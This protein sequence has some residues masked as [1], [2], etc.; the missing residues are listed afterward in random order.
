[1]QNKIIWFHIWRHVPLSFSV[2]K[3]HLLFSLYFHRYTHGSVWVLPEINLGIEGA[4]KAWPILSSGNTTSRRWWSDSTD[5]NQGFCSG[6]KGT[7]ICSRV[8]LEK[9][10]VHL[11]P[12]GTE[13]GRFIL[14]FPPRWSIQAA[15]LS[16]AQLI[17]NNHWS[18]RTHRAPLP[19]SLSLSSEECL[20]L[21]VTKSQRERRTKLV[22]RGELKMMEEIRVGWNPSTI[23]CLYAADFCLEGEKRQ[24]S[25]WACATWLKESEHL[26]GEEK[27]PLPK[28]EPVSMGPGHCYNHP[29]R[30]P[31][32]PPST[33]A[34][35][36]GRLWLKV[37][38]KEFT[39]H[40]DKPK[41]LIKSPQALKNMF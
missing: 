6:F 21:W 28:P 19:N 1:M 17:P 23:K 26:R 25:P 10:N 7:G 32:L 27:I 37:S 30:R 31:S 29:G 9:E 4:V 35:V 33:P 38:M 14:L 5:V 20:L 22:T 24:V 13:T 36:L 8:H 18:R 39:D 41:Q 2:I 16:Q 3:T 15:C 40:P 34:S 11:L 12:R